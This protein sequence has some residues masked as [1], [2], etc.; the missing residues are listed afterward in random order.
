MTH[1]PKIPSIDITPS[2]PLSTLW[3]GE[4]GWEIH[5]ILVRLDYVSD[6]EYV[7]VGLESSSETSGGPLST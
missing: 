5:F 7:N 1:F 4:V 3:L 2:V 6:P